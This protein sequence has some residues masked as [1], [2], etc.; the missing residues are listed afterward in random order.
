ML[1][2]LLIITAVLSLN[3]DRL[4]VRPPGE[5]G[6]SAERLQSISGIVSKGVAAGGFPGAAVI[7]GRSGAIVYKEGFGRLSWTAGARKV[8]A[9]ESI[10][11]LASLTKV[12][13]A[14]TALM[15]LYDEGKLDLDDKVQRYLPDFVGARKDLVTIRQVLAHRGGLAPGR[16]LWKKATSPAHA[17]EMVLTTKLG[18]Q[19]G[20]MM[21]YS[22]LGGDILGWV[23]EAASGQRLDRF[24]EAKVFGPL[25]MKNTMF[26]PAD[27]LKA[28]IA[29]TEVYPPRG[30]PIR[31][32]V[33]DENAYVLG[34]IVGHAGLFSSASD[35][36]VFAQMML[37]RGI[38]G[39]VRIIADSTIQLFT[40]HVAATRTL[41]WELGAGQHGAGDYLDEHA[42]GHTGFTGTSLWIDPDRDMFVILL[43][44]RI[45]E[46]RARRPSI[47][48]ADIRND[49]TDAAALA[50]L[51][52]DVA[53]VDPPKSFRADRALDW[54]RPAGTRSTRER[55]K[56]AT[57]PTPHPAQR[58]AAT[59]RA[60]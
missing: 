40:E 23:A 31:G 10:Y 54:N 41:G 45:H 28:R 18:Y 17:R 25:G 26:K 57:K 6:M 38:Y 21:D 11:D 4:V 55:V 37:N 58:V 50:V 7:V 15:V 16:V 5:V 60:P 43:T 44:N 32:E 8:S 2:A 24:L 12:V 52:P 46:A 56:P 48:I 51:D 33:H 13:G 9:D 53:I 19:P 22:D 14:T 42:F 20:T 27:S 3:S 1:R 47:V 39:G 59:N 34:G 35:L 49:I 29:P 36:A 30:H